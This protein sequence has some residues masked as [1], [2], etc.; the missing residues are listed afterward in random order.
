[1][2]S[3]NEPLT[4][5]DIDNLKKLVGNFGCVSRLEIKVK[6]E[7]FLDKTKFWVQLK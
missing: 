1:M 7:A 3:S 4:G 6:I 2:D 5:L